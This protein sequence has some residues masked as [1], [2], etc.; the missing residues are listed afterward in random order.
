MKKPQ[1]KPVLK[2][3]THLLLLLFTSAIVTAVCLSFAIGV[4]E[5]R[6]F[7]GY[8]RYPV[9]F[10]LNW[11]PVLVVQ[12]ILLSLLNRQWMSFFLTGAVFLLASIGNFFKLKLRDEPFRFSDIGSIGAAMNVAGNYDLTL[13]KRVLAAIAVVVLISLLLWWLF[14][15]GMKP[16]NRLFVL[17]LAV[18]SCFP[19]WRFAYSDSELYKQTAYHNLILITWDSNE[20]YIANG[21]M[22]PFLHSIT[23]SRDIPPSGYSDAEAAAILSRY[24]EGSIPEERK[25]NV[26]AIQLESFTDL[27]KMGVEGISEDVYV[28]LR[29]LETECICGTLVPNIIGGGTIDTERC[30]IGGTYGMQSYHGNCF[31]YAR[32]LSSQGY[33]TSFGHPNRAYYYNRQSVA[34]YLGFDDA[35]FIDNYYQAVTG[36]EWR[37]DSTFLPDVF[38]QFGEDITGEQPVF[39]FRVTLQGHSPYNT[40]S[41]DEDGHFW[42]T[43]SASEETLYMVN[44]YLGMIA[45]TQRYLLEGIDTLRD[46]PEPCVV[47]F[48]GDHNPRFD[49]KTVYQDLGL[50][51]DMST[52]KGFLDYYSTPWLLWANDA[53]KQVLGNDFIGVGPLISPGYMMNVLYEELGWDGCAFMQFTDSIMA[54]MSVVTTNGYYMENG[55]YT[56]EPSPEGKAM[57]HDYECVQYYLH[58]QKVA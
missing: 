58:H 22:Y 35:Y 33:Y 15:G 11:I 4:Y 19:L 14:K 18:L 44:N 34:Y 8:F 43:S 7:F 26:L 25:V 48:Y 13:S 53:A 31:S 36:G 41:Y 1:N 5:W 17:L 46:N 30:F 3:E 24:E 39:S 2:T 27:E 52:E 54:R 12:A 20:Y 16:G 23:D 40:T 10:I 50:T 9:I 29:K 21:F 51:F 6:I 56:T 45:E 38:R 55:D 47:L 42:P 32:A 37:C 49:G 57:L 28:P